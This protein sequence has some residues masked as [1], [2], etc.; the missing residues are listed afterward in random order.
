MPRV[1]YNGPREVFDRVFQAVKL[2]K[3][4]CPLAAHV[5]VGLDLYRTGIVVGS[6][7]ERVGCG[8]VAGGAAAQGADVVGVDGDG[9][10]EVFQGSSLVALCVV[11]WA[12]LCGACTLSLPGAAVTMGMPN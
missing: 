1:Q 3:H 12:L 2:D 7:C 11:C 6:M 10:V 5:G 9:C 4:L 8:S